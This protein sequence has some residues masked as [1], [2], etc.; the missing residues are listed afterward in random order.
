MRVVSLCPSITETVFA[1]GRGDWL[2]GRSKFCVKPE[3]AV[4]AVPRLGGTKNPKLD[5][6]VAAR[7][8][9]VL[10]NDEENRKEDAE[11]LVAAGV[12]VCSTFP[13]T[14]AGAA[15]S[16]RAFG[17][18]L[19]ARAAARRICDA[20]EAEAGVPASRRVRFAYV[21]WRAPWMS[22]SADT[23]I[24]DL[25]AHAGGENVFA[26]RAERYPEVGADELRA[27]DLVLLSSEP[28]PFADKHRGEVGLPL[29]RVLLCDGERL[30]WHGAR[31]P[32]GLA[33]A[34]E[35]LR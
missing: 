25:L 27:A 10:M 4:D 9:V 33:Y 20:I 34:R 28:F 1:L 21:I 8:D 26:A 2:V 32:A 35:L 16:V 17:E 14:V 15:D 13:R 11:A 19:D 5:A 3:G 31:T 12:K 24:S 22:L 30:S 6:I 29:E 23:Y 7:P 18:L